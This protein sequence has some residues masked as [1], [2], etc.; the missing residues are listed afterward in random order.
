MHFHRWKRREFIIVLGGAAAW[1]LAARAQQA[2][3]MRR[4][5]VLLP[6]E[7]GDPESQHRVAAF[8]Q[9]LQQL[10]WTEGAN[11]R[12]EYRWPGADPP[13]IRRHAAELAALNPDLILTSTALA[14]LPLQQ[15]TSVIPIVFTHIYD[16]VDTGF[17]ASLNRP[18]G[19]VTGFALGEFSLGGK[20]LDVLKEVAPQLGRVAVVLNPDQSPQVALWR[21][22]ESAAPALGV[23][24]TA[25]DGHEA[26]K[27]ERAIEAFARE[28]NGGLVVLPSPITSIHREQVTAL[29]AR[30]GLPAVYGFRYFATSGGLVSYGI[31]PVDLFGRAAG[32]VDRILKGAKPADL[33]VQQPTKFELVI[34]LK[35]AKSLGLQIPDR[36]LA[37]AD[38]V[39]E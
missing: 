13:R 6:W 10:G 24:L 8:V 33:P 27:I 7:T 26:A 15:Q 16:P 2:E 29:A 19:N 5:G 25:I 17:V 1:P 9:S 3:R 30:H 32:Y 31:D 37:L 23:R 18:G 20:M 36:L 21:A 35:T 4:I 39:I 28:P 22:I 11:L 38:E 14:L 34:N 12:I